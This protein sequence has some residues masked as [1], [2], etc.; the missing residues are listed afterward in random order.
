MMPSLA[1]EMVEVGEASG[2]LAPML[3][4]VAIF[5]EEET[6]IRTNAL[7]TVIEP[8]ILVFMAL[9]VAF[10]LISLY[11]PLFSINVGSS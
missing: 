3:N 5:Y 8:A 11:L 1:L 4:S 9:I 10:V 6:A 2:A 7:I